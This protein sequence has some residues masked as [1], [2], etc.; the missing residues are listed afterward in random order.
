MSILIVV[1]CSH[2]GSIENHYHI[3]YCSVGTNGTIN[4]LVMDLMGP[5]IEDIFIYSHRE[6]TFKTALALGIQMLKCIQQIHAKNI[7]HR[8]IKPNNF[9]MGI[10]KNCSIM[11]LIDFGLSKKYQDVDASQVDTDHPSDKVNLTLEITF[12]QTLLWM[13]ISFEFFDKYLYN[14][15]QE[16]SEG[17][18]AEI[19]NLIQYCRNLDIDE[20]PDYDGIFKSLRNLLRTF[21]QQVFFI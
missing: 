16:L 20:I 7:L 12:D 13:K 1:Y 10:K 17:C 11:Y 4:Y 6:F 21:W 18:P 19:E 3:F 9:V 2:F 14:N 5:T 8:D 15:L